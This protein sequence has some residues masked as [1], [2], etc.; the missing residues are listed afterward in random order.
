MFIHFLMFEYFWLQMTFPKH[1]FC[2]WLSKLA[3]IQLQTTSLLPSQ[4]L[5]SMVVSSW[6]LDYVAEMEITSILRLSADQIALVCSLRFGFHFMIP[7][8]SQVWIFG[9]VCIFKTRIPDLLRITE[10]RLV[11]WQCVY[12]D[13]LNYAVYY[14][15]HK[16]QSLFPMLSTIQVI[17]TR[18]CFLNVWYTSLICVHS[19]LEHGLVTLTGIFS[20]L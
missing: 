10:Q 6:K 15:S 1:A 19:N 20:P 8:F 16:H 17:N 2:H 11:I 13:Q 12:T 3:Q 7:F 18:V 14:S 5:M 4:G 9:E